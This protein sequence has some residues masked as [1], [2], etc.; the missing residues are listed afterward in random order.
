MSIFVCIFISFSRR[1]Y[2]ILK[3]FRT[4]SLSYKCPTYWNN[5]VYSIVL[6]ISHFSVFPHLIV[7]G[8]CI[9]LVVGKVS[10]FRSLSPTFFNLIYLWYSY[11]NSYR[12][13][14][15]SKNIYHM[16][17]DFADLTDWS[18]ML[19]PIISIGRF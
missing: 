7:M 4:E 15:N 3:L 13:F 11:R 19:L 16:S 12:I 6:I 18:W 5:L 17:T 1:N 8:W 14:M 2:F 9:G 10:F